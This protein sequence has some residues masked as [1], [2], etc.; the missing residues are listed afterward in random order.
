MSL[1]ELSRCGASDDRRRSMRSLVGRDR[2]RALA[3]ISSIRRSPAAMT[4]GEDAMASRC[5]EGRDPAALPWRATCWRA[6]SLLPA[7]RNRWAAW[8]RRLGKALDRRERGKSGPENSTDGC[9]VQSRRTSGRIPLRSSVPTGSRSHRRTSLHSERLQADAHPDEQPAAAIE[10]EARQLLRKAKRAV[11]EEE[12]DPSSKLDPRRE[13]GGASRAMTSVSWKVGYS[14]DVD[15]HPRLL[16]HGSNRVLSVQD[17]VKASH[18]CFE[19]DQRSIEVGGRIRG[20]LWGGFRSQPPFPPP[21]CRHG[22]CRH[23]RG[24]HGLADVTALTLNLA[25]P[26]S[27]TGE[28][29]RGLPMSAHALT[30]A[31]RC[32]VRQYGEAAAAEGPPDGSHPTWDGWTTRSR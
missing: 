12:E 18:L 14:V 13:R 6:T 17:E 25:P 16:I 4:S 26:P 10:I 20:T 22:R 11:L 28:G 23:C 3:A 1:D 7:K 21:R 9:S 30:R 19:R 24:R 15:T 2:G 5:D 8:S 27:H 32:R 31:W 29:R